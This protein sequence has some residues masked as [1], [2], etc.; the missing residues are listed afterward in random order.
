MMAENLIL[1]LQITLVGMGLV[2]GAL[3]LLW[4]L[5]LGLT[6]I[7]TEKKKNNKTRARVAHE[8]EEE[9]AALAVATA[10]AEQSQGR[11]S[12]FPVPPTAIVSAWQL[13]LRSRQINRGE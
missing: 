5:M 7:T 10:I 11:V 3:I 6:T 12:R 8:L 9:A 4:L 2:F 1:S 13:S